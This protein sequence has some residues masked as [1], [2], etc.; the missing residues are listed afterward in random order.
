MSN[1]NVFWEESK[2]INVLTKLRNTITLASFCARCGEDNGSIKFSANSVGGILFNSYTGAGFSLK[3]AFTLECWFKTSQV[4]NYA[5]SQLN[6]IASSG[7]PVPILGHT[8]ISLKQGKIV[9]T[10]YK[11]GVSS[12][13]TSASNYPLGTWTHVAATFDG[14]IVKIYQ[15]GIQDLKT[16]SIV[17]ALDDNGGLYRF[18][19]GGIFTG[20]E[21]FVGS[22]A[23]ARVWTKALARTEIKAG[24]NFRRGKNN[25]LSRY[26]RFN[27]T[28]GTSPIAD[29]LAGTPTATIPTNTALDNSDYP[30]L[31]TGASTLAAIFNVTAGQ[32]I[33]LKY[34]IRKPTDANFMLC[35]SYIANSKVT[36][37]KLWEQTGVNIAPAPVRYRGQVL[38]TTFQFEVWGVDGAEDCELTDDL[39]IYFSKCSLPNTDRDTTNVALVTSPTID[40]TLGV[41]FGSAFPLVFNTAQ[42][43]TCAAPVAQTLANMSAN[44]TVYGAT[45]GLDAGFLNE[46]G[47]RAL[48]EDGGQQL[49]EQ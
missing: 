12:V 3:S 7:N 6:L 18:T 28:T 2:R 43:G 24:M 36:R 8:S 26:I 16:L 48:N 31:I 35:V 23:E 4:G 40:T 1:N 44:L 32:N 30:P 33:S 17:A 37:Y 45:G 47:G 13:L 10:V 27:D 25:G 22:I 42:Y 49:V 38:P 5:G 11:D 19:C 21:I 14:T 34:P 41:A 9:V 29:Y 39:I 15:N 46:D 20:T